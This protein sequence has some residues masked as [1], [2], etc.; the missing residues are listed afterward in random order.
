MPLSFQVP[1]GDEWCFGGVQGDAPV[2]GVFVL[3]SLIKDFY[4]TFAIYFP[5]LYVGYTTI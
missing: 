1:F 3:S 4:L 5:I 2:T